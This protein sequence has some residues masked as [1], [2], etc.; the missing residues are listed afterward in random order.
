MYSAQPLVGAV[1]PS[2][3]RTYCITPSDATPAVM[4]DTL[5][6][7]L[8]PATKLLL[9]DGYDRVDYDTS[10]FKPGCYHTFEIRWYSDQLLQ[11]IEERTLA[12]LAENRPE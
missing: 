6:V 1:I 10:F 3:S 2:E 11:N 7:T 9:V 5:T 12:W 4:H 8:D